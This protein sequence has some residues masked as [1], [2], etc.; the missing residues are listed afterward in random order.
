MMTMFSMIKFLNS[1]L[2]IFFWSSTSPF[3]E[4]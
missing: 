3:T 4:S 1:S 2:S